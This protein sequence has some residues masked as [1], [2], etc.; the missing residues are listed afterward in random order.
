LNDD[1]HKKSIRAIGD[2]ASAA[3]RLR[4]QVLAGLPA[5]ELRKS[6]AGLD[7]ITKMPA[8]RLTVPPLG[9]EIRVPPNPAIKTNAEIQRLN[10]QM[11]TLVDVTTTLAKATA[12]MAWLTVAIL[13]VGLAGLGLSVYLAFG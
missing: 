12:R 10:D 5:G 8:L 9:P 2:A 3:A 4:T 13:L 1:E 11:E 6:I 7:K